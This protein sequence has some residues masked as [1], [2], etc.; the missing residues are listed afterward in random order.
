[1]DGTSTPVRAADVLFQSVVVPAGH[2]VVTL[3]YH[4]TSV[5]VGLV[6]SGAGLV[7]FAGLLAVPW[8]VAR[9]RRGRGAAVSASA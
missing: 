7:G 4:P 6:A 3:R 9:R 8:L 1:M 5:T 2:H